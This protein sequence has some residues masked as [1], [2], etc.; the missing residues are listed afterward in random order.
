MT[1]FWQRA[2]AALLAASLFVPFLGC[3]SRASQMEEMKR[4]ALKRVS[5]EEEDV[6]DS[7]G[8]SQD[9]RVAAQVS[10]PEVA[11]QD[12]Q[13][14][15]VVKDSEPPNALSPSHRRKRPESDMER[16][17]WAL[18]NLGKI[19]E[20]LLA[21]LEDKRVYMPTSIRDGA[22]VPLLSWRVALLPYLG[23]QELYSKFDITQPWDSKKN[24]ALLK[25]I[26]DVYRSPERMDEKTNFLAPHGSTTLF[27]TSYDPI[28][29]VR[30]EDGLSNTIA[31][32]EVDDELA[33]EWT[34]PVEFS[35]DLES[36]GVGSKRKD[37]I[38]VAFGDGT[39]RRIPRTVKP[40][41]FLALMTMDG[42]EPVTMA[43][44]S[45]AVAAD[46][47]VSSEVDN[48][49]Y[50]KLAGL[51]A[52]EADSAMDS[53]NG[54][55]NPL[56]AQRQREEANAV[57]RPAP[58]PESTLVDA[59][60]LFREI[61]GPKYQEAAKEEDTRKLA[62]EI[63]EKG[64][65][66]GEDPAGR[67]VLL[68]AARRIATEVRDVSLT[69]RI[70]A[71][72]SQHY[73]IDDYPLRVE[74]LAAVATRL[75]ASEIE[76]AM[77][78]AKAGVARDDFDSASQVLRWASAAV[79]LDSDRGKRNRGPDD[80]RD[81]LASLRRRV[82]R[83]R[84]EYRRF[85][86]ELSTVVSGSPRSNTI[87]GRYLCLVKQQWLKGL[88]LLAACDDD[89][90]RSVA[91]MELN[92]LPTPLQRLEIGDAWWKYGEKHLVYRDVAWR[93]AALWLTAA[94]ES[95]PDGLQRVKAEM[96]LNEITKELGSDAISQ[97]R[98]RFSTRQ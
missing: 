24:L 6:D 30:I 53:Q 75:P 77:D 21:Y 38:F 58:P 93:H 92:K 1:F 54:R 65:G 17:A 28:P 31:V 36:R 48:S 51:G 10:S 45:F 18:D 37:G 43:K 9:A 62:E 39:V 87:A 79:K 55:P 64:Q 91:Q 97:V 84:N 61:Y 4:R 94:E 13:P 70:I 27:N 5:D 78:V 60:K 2:I 86:T 73:R 22:G 80:K 89:E 16:R 90:L 76:M 95:L 63:F 35:A 59:R 11:K 47:A 19:S 82:E 49:P 40:S 33:V 50:E 67:F 72:L 26:P 34:K 46:P 98:S 15:P 68:Q 44:V 20:G 96:R 29:R 32:L 52:R 71:E 8:A 41:E 12:S 85:R 3:D 74:L 14:T 7:S 56:D 81:E 69:T 83:G 88:P 23:H 66:M 57:E 42:G 25:E